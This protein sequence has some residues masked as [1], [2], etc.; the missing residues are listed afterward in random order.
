MFSIN[1]RYHGMAFLW[2]PYIPNCS[3]SFHCEGHE[4]WFFCPSVAGYGSDYQVNVSGRAR[5][6]NPSNSLKLIHFPSHWACWASLWPW[7]S[8]AG[9]EETY[10]GPFLGYIFFSSSPCP[11]F[12]LKHWWGS[13]WI[14]NMT[15]PWAPPLG[16][17]FVTVANF[18]CTFFFNV[19]KI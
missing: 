13:G 18:F 2:H 10:L 15:V 4:P 5:M 11:E 19:F 7:V 12:I 3:R 8:G 9:L 14:I 6:L 1:G 17:L 16:L